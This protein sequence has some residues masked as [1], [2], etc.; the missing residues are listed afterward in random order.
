MHRFLLIGAGPLGLNV[1]RFILQRSSLELLGI[2]DRNQDIYGK[3]VSD[4]V[5]GAASGLQ[6]NPRDCTQ[7]ASVSN[8]ICCGD[9]N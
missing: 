8:I 6:W 2:V 4:S 5:G 1:A 3:K 7:I 9:V